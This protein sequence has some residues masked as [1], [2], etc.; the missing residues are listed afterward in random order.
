M[1][2]RVWNDADLVVPIIFVSNFIW[3]MCNLAA[4][5]MIRNLLGAKC[6]FPYSTGHTITNDIVRD[7]LWWL[8]FPLIA[9]ACH[10]LYMD[11]TAVVKLSQHEVIQGH[12]WFPIAC[13]VV[14]VFA[15][16]KV[17]LPWAGLTAHVLRNWM[18]GYIL[19]NGLLAWGI[20]EL[21]YH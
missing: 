20:Y 5:W 7:S 16:H 18:Y 4:V 8:Q 9:V 14:W 10:R 17:I 12:Y 21:F 1:V 3:A 19:F 15:A 2:E 6:F 11:F 13:I